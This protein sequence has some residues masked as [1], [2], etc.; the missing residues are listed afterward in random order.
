MLYHPKGSIGVD[1]GSGCQE[2]SK[3]VHN[4]ITA[5][6][7]PE[8]QKYAPRGVASHLEGVLLT[9]TTKLQPNEHFLTSVQT[10]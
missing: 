1:W 7:M 3:E 5:L 10:L 2:L 4:T 8:I 6:E 9:L